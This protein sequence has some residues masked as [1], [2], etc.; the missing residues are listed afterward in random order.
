MAAPSL[1]LHA[2][3]QWH[4]ASVVARASPVNTPGCGA[5]HSSSFRLSLCSQ[6]HGLVLFMSF[7]PHCLPV[8]TQLSV[9]MFPSCCGTKEEAVQWWCQRHSHSWRLGRRTPSRW[10]PDVKCQLGCAACSGISWYYLGP[11][12]HIP[13]LQS[14][15]EPSVRTPG[16][17]PRNEL[18]VSQAVPPKWRSRGAV[19]WGSGQCLVGEWAQKIGP[20]SH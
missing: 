8:L 10:L 13:S 4:F 2:T 17:I 3:Q 18:G 5:P 1:P 7:L 11:R 12:Y 16:H 9:E 6:H 20:F 19:Q 14:L 15:Q